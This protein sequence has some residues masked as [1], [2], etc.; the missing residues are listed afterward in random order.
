MEYNGNMSKSI[1]LIAYMAAMVL[2]IV[3]ADVL[4]FRERFW[5]RL[6]ANIGI[7]AVF[8]ALYL[9]FLK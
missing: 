4:F 9:A 1:L 3:G 7:V 5:E 2:V 8:L 6:I